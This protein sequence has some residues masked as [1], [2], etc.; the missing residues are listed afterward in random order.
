MCVCWC[1][2][3]CEFLCASTPA[4]SWPYRSRKP[5]KESE[6]ISG[7]H[8]PDVMCLNRE[9]VHEQRSSRCLQ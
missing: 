3:A 5:E 4:Q 1:V 8:A 6:T 7:S 9:A 2:P